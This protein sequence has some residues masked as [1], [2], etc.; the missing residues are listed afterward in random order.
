MKAWAWRPRTRITVEDRCVRGV[1]WDAWSFGAYLVSMCTS[2][3]DYLIYESLS[4]PGLICCSRYVLPISIENQNE[5]TTA[6]IQSH[7]TCTS[8][9]VSPI[10]LSS[11]TIHF[12]SQDMSSC[13]LNC[14]CI[15]FSFSSCIPSHLSLPY[16]LIYPS[17][18]FERKAIIQSQPV[19]NTSSQHFAQSSNSPSLKGRSSH[20]SLSHLCPTSI[21]IYHIIRSANHPSQPFIFHLSLSTHPTPFLTMQK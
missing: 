2:P 11:H 16:V 13:V 3:L 9:P 5:S 20:L 1:C 8:P 21:L 14:F 12:A 6:W 15:I 4:F 10:F 18:L 7:S 19:P 17:S